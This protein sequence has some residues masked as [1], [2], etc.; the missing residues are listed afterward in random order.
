MNRSEVRR[1]ARAHMRRDPHESARHRERLWKSCGRLS[2]GLL[3]LLLLLLLAS[4]LV[5][6][7]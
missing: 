2:R 7:L 4:L 3:A 5:A 1:G 6:L